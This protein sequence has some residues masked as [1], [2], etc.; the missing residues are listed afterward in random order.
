VRGSLLSVTSA[1]EDTIDFLNSTL[2]TIERNILDDAAAAQTA[3][4]AEVEK[5]V[6]G[7]GGIFGLDNI[8]IPQIELPSVSQLSNITIPD[9]IDKALESLNNSIPTFDEVKNATDSA[10]S[11]P[12]DLLK[13]D[14]ESI[15]L[16]S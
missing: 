7:I 5:V 6:G 14:S 1:A 13:V 15:E 2:S 11:F 3:I 8:T 16:S 9:T 4:V 12:F 10:I